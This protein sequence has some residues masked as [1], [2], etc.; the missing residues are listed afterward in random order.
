MPS[1]IIASASRSSPRIFIYHSSHIILI[2]SSFH[3]I[4]LAFFTFPLIH[5]TMVLFAISSKLIFTHFIYHTLL[6]IIPSSYPSYFDSITLITTHPCFSF[7]FASMFSI[8]S[9][10]SIPISFFLSVTSITLTLIHFHS[11][12][13]ILYH[14][15]IPIH[16]LSLF[17]LFIL[18]RS[19]VSS[20]FIIHRSFI[21]CNYILI[22]LFHTLHPIH[23][24]S[25]LPIIV[26]QLWDQY[27]VCLDS[28]YHIFICC[29]DRKHSLSIRRNRFCLWCMIRE[30]QH[31]MMRK[32]ENEYL[33]IGGNRCAISSNHRSRFHWMITEGYLHQSNT[34]S[35]LS[36]ITEPIYLKFWSFP[37]NSVNEGRSIHSS[38]HSISLRIVNVFL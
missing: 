16:F 25:S 24:F 12:P 37:L 28:Y 15:I 6:F 21:S 19:V 35:I 23:L 4:I 20:S 2:P 36:R 5:F 27:H 17:W 30:Q 33:R 31:R 10:P 13:L 29:V 11:N 8:H 26:S 3:S 34:K 32:W 7:S 14:F 18:T 22:H 38:T 1:L 9:L